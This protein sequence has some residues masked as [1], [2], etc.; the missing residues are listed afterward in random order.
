MAILVIGRGI[1]L[2]IVA[3]YA[4]SAAWTLHL[5]N[6]GVPILLAMLMAYLF[7]LSAGVL[8]GVLIAYVENAGRCSRLWAWASFIYG[9]ARWALVPL[10]VVYMPA[11]AS[12]HSPG[13][14]V[15]S[16][17]GLPTPILF[18][19]IVALLGFCLPAFHQSGAVHL[20]DWRQSCGGAHLG[21]AGAPDRRPA[22]RDCGGPVAYLA[23]IITATAVASMDTAVANPR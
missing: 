19:A 16:S 8:S 22:I 14:A 18:F 17:F 9:F 15:G 4:M 20:R 13:L 5:A 1:D 7:A 6:G 2:A 23:G 11:S 21:R 12:A 3:I 10:F